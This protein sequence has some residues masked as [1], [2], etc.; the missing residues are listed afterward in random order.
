[1]LFVDKSKRGESDLRVQFFDSPED[2]AAGQG[3][4]LL[5]PY[6]K[7]EWGSVQDYVIGKTNSGDEQLILQIPFDGGRCP[8]RLADSAGH[9]LVLTVTRF[10]GEEKASQLEFSLFRKMQSQ[11]FMY[12]EMENG[13]Q[14]RVVVDPA[15]ENKGS[16][17]N[18]DYLYCQA[19][20]QGNIIE[21]PR[22]CFRQ[23][24]EV[25]GTFLP[26][27]IGPGGLGVGGTAV[28]NTVKVPKLRMKKLPEPLKKACMRCC[29]DLKARL[30]YLNARKQ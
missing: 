1:M 18:P 17:Y 2:L 7:S 15:A 6:C 21:N 19:D 3:M 24:R 22:R 23:K 25:K 8:A 11:S 26:I 12:A 28:W 4:D 5:G 16:L 13:E 30:I 20:F 29:C 27:G 9:P 10:K 14:F